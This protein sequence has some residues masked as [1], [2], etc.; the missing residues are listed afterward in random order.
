MTVAIVVMVRI[1]LIDSMVDCATTTSPA[2]SGREWVKLCS[3]C[4]T[5]A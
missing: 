1:C 2:C 5:I 3:P 4:T